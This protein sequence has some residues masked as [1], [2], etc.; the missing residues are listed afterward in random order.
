MKIVKCSKEKINMLI[1]S[2]KELERKDLRC[3]LNY[4]L[5]ENFADCS[6]DYDSMVYDITNISKPGIVIN[7]QD[8]HGNRGA[9]DSIIFSTYVITGVKGKYIGVIGTGSV[10]CLYVTDF[11]EQCIVHMEDGVIDKSKFG[12]VRKFITD[13]IISEINDVRNVVYN[14]DYYEIITEHFK[15]ILEVIS[16]KYARARFTMFIDDTLA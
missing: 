15:G 3:S 13:K 12:N 6:A 4:A 14:E 16:E 8:V 1:N 2:G 5:H 10:S 11:K 9:I 7:I